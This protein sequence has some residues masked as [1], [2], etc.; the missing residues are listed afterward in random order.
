MLSPI[1]LKI[2]RKTGLIDLFKEKN[3]EVGVEIGTDHGGYARDICER[4]PEVRL[5]T[6]DPF[7]AYTEGDDV[8][9]QED[10]DQIH[11]EAKDLL[12]NYWNCKLVRKTSMDAVK[13]YK[14]NSID[15]VFIDGNHEF[16]HVYEDIVEWTKIVKSGGIVCGHDYKKDD[17]L[18]YGVIEAVNKYVEENN[19]PLY[20]LRKGTF[21]DC[22]MFY[23]P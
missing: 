15:F 23:K 3:F 22:W 10:V 12:S 18:K 17:K 9:S 19:I 8:K 16:D 2:T 21:V 13:D 11:Q 5:T 20:I 6:I 1:I 4:Y 7:V 14:P